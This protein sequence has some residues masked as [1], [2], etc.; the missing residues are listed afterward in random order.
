[1]T[2]ITRS[3][4]PGAI[5]LKT[6]CGKTPKFGKDCHPSGIPWMLGT[7]PGMTIYTFQSL[8]SWPGLSGPVPAIQ[9]WSA[10][11]LLPQLLSQTLPENGGKLF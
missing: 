3:L 9:P 7:R 1:V 6:G 5:Y 2:Q 8:A 10:M 11:R 4:V